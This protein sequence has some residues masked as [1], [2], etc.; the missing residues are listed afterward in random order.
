M[1]RRTDLLNFI[2]TWHEYTRLIHIFRVAVDRKDLHIAANVD[3][4]LHLGLRIQAY[5]VVKQQIAPRRSHDFADANTGVS[6]H[7]SIL[8]QSDDLASLCRGHHHSTFLD[9]KPFVN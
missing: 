9:L 6:A 2:S 1:L 3:S 5:A 4:Q 8:V 7:L